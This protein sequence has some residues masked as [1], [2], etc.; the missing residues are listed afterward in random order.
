MLVLFRISAR[1][2]RAHSEAFMRTIRA[3]LSEITDRDNWP[4]HT[5]VQTKVPPRSWE[6]EQV[7]AGFGGGKVL[8][9]LM[10]D[11]ASI[12]GGVLCP[13]PR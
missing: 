8:S 13:I 11:L 6:Y 12:R 7:L 5:E 9:A 2:P 1:M 4:K 3:W 10:F